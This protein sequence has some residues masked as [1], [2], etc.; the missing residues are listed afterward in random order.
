MLSRVIYINILLLAK[1]RKNTLIIV[2]LFSLH[3]IFP[4]TLISQTKHSKYS[5]DNKKMKKRKIRNRFTLKGLLIKDATKAVRK[6]VKEDNKRQIKGGKY[7]ERTIFKYQKKVNN[8]NELGKNRKVYKRMREFSRIAKRRRHNK[9]TKN[10][11]QRLFLKIK[12]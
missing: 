9:P 11:F 1:V 12:L 5:V 7:N 8:N 4:Q 10:F 3:L 2:L 6:Q